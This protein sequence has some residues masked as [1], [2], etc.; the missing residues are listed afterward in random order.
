MAHLDSSSVSDLTEDSPQAPADDGQDVL[1]Q[2]TNQD[3]SG[4]SAAE[5]STACEF[6]ASTL[7]DPLPLGQQTQMPAGGARATA[8]G[9][10]LLCPCTD[11]QPWVENTW[12]YL[13]ALLMLRPGSH[14]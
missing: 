1:M 13:G 10:A 8:H 7:Q 3:C 4:S 2:R 6:R 5:G 11:S 12:S 14:V 9:S